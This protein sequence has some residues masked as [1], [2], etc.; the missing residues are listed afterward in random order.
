[1]GRGGGAGEGS[2]R[3]SHGV[4]GGKGE[5]GVMRGIERRG[6]GA[7]GRTEKRSKRDGGQRG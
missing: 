2:V 3:R 4:R 5:V 7:Y 1:M 6:L